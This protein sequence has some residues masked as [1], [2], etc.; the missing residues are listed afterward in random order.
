VSAARVELSGEIDLAAK[1]DVEA[2]LTAAARTALAD[3]HVLEVNLAA[4]TFLDSTGLSCLAKA[5]KQMAEGGG[6]L[7]VTGASPMVLRVFEIA[8]LSDLCEG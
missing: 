7:R 3:G 8:G 2:Q 6:R 4:V 1:I 5:S